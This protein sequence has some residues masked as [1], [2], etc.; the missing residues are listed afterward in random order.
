MR[1]WKGSAVVWK[2]TRRRWK[3]SSSG[4][5]C[6]CVMAGGHEW[7]LLPELGIL[8]AGMSCPPGFSLRVC[9]CA[10]CTDRHPVFWFIKLN[11]A[12][13]L[14]GAQQRGC[15]AFGL[16]VTS[17]GPGPALH[18]CSSPLPST[19][20]GHGPWLVWW[21]R[22]PTGPSLIGIGIQAR[23]HLPAAVQS[24]C[25]AHRSTLCFPLLSSCLSRSTARDLQVCDYPDFGQAI[26]FI[27][28]PIRDK[29]NFCFITDSWSREK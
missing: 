28:T 19:C 16:C 13:D 25:C 27:L 12:G 9:V 3:C 17:S 6:R 24:H 8:P 11:Q 10:F 14:P 20:T 21:V 26:D 4:L 18:R 5:P 1:S 23:A 29:S 2:K 22:I 7:R 15:P